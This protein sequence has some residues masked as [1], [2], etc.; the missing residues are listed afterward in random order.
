MKTKLFILL[1]VAILAGCTDEETPNDV[2]CVKV[3][4][5]RALCGQAILE[6]MDPAYFHKGQSWVDG[7]GE[8]YNNVFSTL[9]PCDFNQALSSGDEFIIQFSD[10]LIG[11]N[12]ATCYALLEGP[13]K[14][15]YVMACLPTSGFE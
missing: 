15:S 8:E 2:G 9:I 12:C 11:G 7:V 13:E 5:V 4:L 10:E 1:F 6:I 3:K 14:F